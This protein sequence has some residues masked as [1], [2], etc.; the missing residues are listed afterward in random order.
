M[1]CYPLEFI[2][3][4]IM[5]KKFHVML[6]DLYEKHS[7]GGFDWFEYETNRRRRSYLGSIIK[8]Q[9]ENKDD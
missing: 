3:R 6:Q 9:Q 1:Y 5:A 4:R 8:K 2:G 7:G